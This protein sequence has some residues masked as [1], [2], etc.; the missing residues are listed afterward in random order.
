MIE[1]SINEASTKD[2]GS[3][4]KG[5]HQISNVRLALVLPRSFLIRPEGASP[6]TQT[7]T[8]HQN[9]PR[10]QRGEPE[11]PQAAMILLHGRGDSAQGILS[12][13]DHLLRPGWTFIAPQAAG[14][15]WYPN[16]FIA[17]IQ[18]NEPWLGSALQ[19]VTDT[20]KAVHETGVPNDRVIL[21]GFSQGACLA[22]EAAARLGGRFGGV[23][24]LSGG[25]IGDTLDPTR[26]KRLELTRVFLGCSDTDFHIPLERVSETAVILENLG[27]RVD[28]RIYP[29]FGHTVNEDELDAVREMMKLVA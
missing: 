23:A 29:N 15:A 21:L 12:L 13:A 8:L 1:R 18:S 27:A 10:L 6:M 7:R 26:Y 25:L 11:T 16:R 17:P 19:V 24:G 9:Q 5:N 2:E 28:T 4:A 20:L 22:L 3:R 14:N